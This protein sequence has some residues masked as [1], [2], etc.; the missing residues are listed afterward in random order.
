VFPFSVAPRISAILSEFSQRNT[1]VSTLKPNGCLPHW[2]QGHHLEAKGQAPRGLIAEEDRQCAI[3]W[4]T[5]TAEDC[6]RASPQDREFSKVWVTIFAAIAADSSPSNFRRIPM[7]H[8]LTLRAG[9]PGNCRFIRKCYA[10]FEQ[11][12][13]AAERAFVTGREEY[14]IE[15]ERGPVTYRLMSVQNSCE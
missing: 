2:A 13:A 10:S 12:Y 4:L 3:R 9:Q 11:A 14:L 6:D 7:S 1:P 5:R 15:D 8:F